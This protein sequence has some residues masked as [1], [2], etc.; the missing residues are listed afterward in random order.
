MVLQNML[1]G[2]HFSDSYN[3]RDSRVSVTL[4]IQYS[5]SIWSILVHVELLVM[6]K[7]LLCSGN[8]HPLC[9][10][11]AGVNH[12]PSKLYYIYVLNIIVNATILIVRS[13]WCDL[14]SA[15][16]FFVEILAFGS[17]V[18]GF[19]LLLYSSTSAIQYSVS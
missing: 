4:F 18:L 3:G 7:S 5:S 14:M 1:D 12:D 6:L 9:Y 2:R 8:M 15:H 17:I 19:V 10:F 16:F 13:L 11:V